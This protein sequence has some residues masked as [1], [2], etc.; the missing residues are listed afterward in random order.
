MW[1]LWGEGEIY[2]WWLCK[3]AIRQSASESSGM[4]LLF[5]TSSVMS[6]IV[7]PEV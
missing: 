7:A 2:V 5:I 1:A 6:G 4:M 3:S